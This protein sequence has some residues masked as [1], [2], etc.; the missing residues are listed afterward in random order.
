MFGKKSEAK[1]AGGINLAFDVGIVVPHT[2][3]NSQQ[4]VS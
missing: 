1:I 3:E 2:I 4:Q